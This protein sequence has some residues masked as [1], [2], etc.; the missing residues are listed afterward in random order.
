[1]FGALGRGSACEALLVTLKRRA[2]AA[3][4]GYET[5][6]WLQSGDLH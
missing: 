4:K 3:I 1:M 2:N 5:V 6:C